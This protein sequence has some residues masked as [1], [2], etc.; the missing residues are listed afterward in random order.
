MTLFTPMPTPRFRPIS[1]SWVALHP[2][3]KGVIQFLGGA[4]FGTFAPMLFYQHLLRYLFDKSYTIVIL[5][6]SFS[7]NHYREAIFLLKEQY[8]LIPELVSLAMAEGAEPEV[9]LKADNYIWV[10]H[11]IG[12]KYIALLESA[13]KLP[14]EEGDLVQYLTEILKQTLPDAAHKKFIRGIAQQLMDLHKGLITDALASKKL[15]SRCEGKKGNLVEQSASD[16][17]FIYNDLFIR[18]QISVLLAPVNSDTSSAVQLKPL[19]RWLDQRGWGVQPTPADTRSL[20][21]KADLFHLLVLAAFKTDKL[22]KETVAWFYNSLDRPDSSERD[23]FHGAHF[24]PLGFSLGDLVINPWFD[25]PLFTSTA[26]R[27][28]ELESRLAAQL[29]ALR[30]GMDRG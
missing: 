7:F 19:A 11:S 9:Y 16:P 22:A 13:G 20:I 23:P 3:P 6:F 8:A 30:D 17:K 1:H 2:Q 28:H 12:C 5:P 25:R 4:F 18:D 29:Q 27:D 10:G 24:R 21:E 26:S 14:F 15:V